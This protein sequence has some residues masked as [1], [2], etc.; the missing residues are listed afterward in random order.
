MPL[1]LYQVAD[2]VL[3]FDKDGSTI[4]HKNR[5][6]DEYQYSDEEKVV[7]KLRSVLT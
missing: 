7:L 2:V 5:N 3:S 4:Y 6:Y 1:K